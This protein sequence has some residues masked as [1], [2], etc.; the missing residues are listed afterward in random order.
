MYPVQAR[1]GRYRGCLLAL[2][3]VG[4][5]PTDRSRA[6][7]LSQAPDCPAAPAGLPDIVE[8]DE[9]CVYYDDTNLTEAQAEQAADDIQ[10]HWDR[11]TDDFGFRTP[12]YTDKLEVRLTNDAGCNGGTWVTW[13]Y[14]TTY[15]GCFSIPEQAE[16]VLGHE[17][18]H[19]VQYSYDGYE[20][21]WFKEGTARTM[22]DMT[23]EHLDHWEDAPDIGF[24]FNDDVD[25][26]LVNTNRD[27]TS[28]PMRYL[29]T[30]WWK[31]FS[32]QYGEE[33]TEPQ[34]GVDAFVDLWESAETRDDIAAVNWTLLTGEEPDAN[35]NAAFRQFT[36]VNWT[37]D[38]NNLPSPTNRY[39][40]LDEDEP[41]N[42]APYGPI[43]PTSG[44]TLNIDNSP[45]NFTNQ[46]ISR[47]GARYYQVQPGSN[48][49]LIS[50]SFS[51]LD[52]DPAFYHVVTQKGANFAAHVSG[53]GTNWTQS[54][55]NDGL[56]AVT[57]IV[58]SEENASDVDVSFLC[59]DPEIAI[60]MPNTGARSF[61]G[62]SAAPGKF[63]AQVLVTNSSIAN[64]PVV[65]GLSVSDF[66]ATVNGVNAF[67]TTGG[68]VQEQYW[69][70]IQAPAQ[71]SD[72]TYDLEITLEAPGTATPIA[73][74]TNATSVTYSPNNL[75]HVLVVDRSGSMGEDNKMEAAKRAA[76][77]YVDI[78]RNNDGLAVVPYNE[79]VNPSPFDMATVNATVRT[80]AHTFVDGLTAGGLTSIGDGLAEAV[81][82]Y[83]ASP[84]DNDNCS[85]VLLSDGM[86]NSDERWA[87]VQSDVVGTGC[88]VTTIAFGQATDE[89]LLQNIASTTGGLFFFNDVYISALA[90]SSTSSSDMAFNLQSTFELADAEVIG[91]ER[92]LTAKGTAP[93]ND[94]Q[95][96]SFLVDDT[97]SEILV[98]LSW[99]PAFGSTV[100]LTVYDP[101]GNPVTGDYV[102][103]DTASGYRGV[104]ID[105]PEPGAWEVGVEYQVPIIT[106][107]PAQVGS[108]PYQ[109]IV[110]GP[111]NLTVDLLLPDRLDQQYFTG[112]SVPIYAFLSSDSGPISGFVQAVVTAPDGTET[113]IPLFDDG[114]HGDGAADD[115]FYAGRYT[116]VNQAEAVSPGETQ[117]EDPPDE[118][119]YQVRV[120]VSRFDLNF[121]REAFGSFA[122][123]EGDDAN[124]NNIPDPFEEEHQL[125]GPGDPDLDL[126]PNEGEYDAGTD[127]NDSDSD[128]GG[129]NDGSEVE[130]GQDPLDP[131]DDQIEA[132]E[133]F[134]ADA[135]NVETYLFYDVKSEYTRIALYRTTDPDGVWN[136][137]GDEPSLT[138][139]HTDTNV[140]NGTT[141]YYRMFGVDED[142]HRSAVLSSEGVT[143][144]ED[145]TPPEGSVLINDDAE[146]TPTLNVS[147]SFVPGQEDARENFDDITE[148]RVSNE[149][150]AVDGA[151][152]QPFAPDIPWTL[153]PTTS[154]DW[155]RVYVQFRDDAGNESVV[156]TDRIIYDPSVAIPVQE[157]ML[158][159]PE[160]GM[161]GT[162]YA[163]TAT[164]SPTSATEPISYT[165]EAT[166]HPMSG[167]VLSDT[168]A[169]SWD[170]AGVKEVRVVAM[171]ATGTASA[172]HTIMI[173]TEQPGGVQEVMLAGPESGMVGTDYAFTA[174]VSPTSATEPISYTWEATDHP[175]SGAVLSDTIAF[176]WD[177]AG[178]KEV[179]V[180]A[181]NATGTASATHTI[182]IST[183][184]PGG[185][186]AVM[187]AGP[188]SGMVGT[189]YAF[190]ATVSPTSATEPISY[191]WEAT[192]QEPVTHDGTTTKDTMTFSWTT[193]GIKE[194]RVTAMN[195][196]GS[197]SASHNITI[198]VE[199]V[200]GALETVTISGTESGQP[201]VAYT[202]TA[203][204]EPSDASQP[205]SYTW[206]ATGQDQVTHTGG[207][208][209][210]TVSFMWTTEGTK[211][212]TVRAENAVNM[213]SD[214]F[215]IE[216]GSGTTGGEGTV[217]LP[218][219]LR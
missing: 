132:P 61:V 184:Q 202:F 74:D 15:S 109:V 158:A 211:E 42:P 4:L 58:G 86:E 164:V 66:K 94:E 78:T 22:Q 133:F 165:W 8:R 29:S 12:L 107:A 210:D 105:N 121:Q 117:G 212:L 146:R 115:G 162:D 174:T 137:L 24:S 217:Y 201:N 160:S 82:Q 138:G 185:V 134:D 88:P 207:G 21:K 71:V 156:D 13:N 26:Y 118:G 104:R 72:G 187:L 204:A 124:S 14:L 209:E 186:Q 122:V 84:T 83:E 135:G 63:L 76:N 17:L 69:L 178:M 195:A 91:R 213:V 106:A 32:E 206:E 51:N 40:Y 126:L 52:N 2:I 3:L 136:L 173:S 28:E 46:Q 6:A 65:A 81:D 123:Q 127:P 114:E 56:T 194:V 77:F 75:D 139:V 208:L 129:E 33:T 90:Q 196:D 87:D 176:L 163:F 182:M 191:T 167:A 170:T 38:L 166:D 155:A 175:M 96:H 36:L 119:S 130:Q 179:R 48:C 97:T 18:F 53:S 101:D 125:A 199:P 54:F 144:S 203:I 172:T 149:E 19:R 79:D 1:A 49:P 11:Y 103:A 89:T 142:N 73:A 140:T 116:L 43:V 5:V 98:A 55:L 20:S 110:S 80:N 85:F 181:M 180:V 93:Q 31:F 37:K 62:P 108:V 189:D 30:L 57:A 131:S 215:S 205:V 169:F 143:P 50:V 95:R 147:L 60:Q 68:F 34:R 183:E 177:T 154:G 64:A 67:I 171:N 218:L 120:S 100:F 59:A 44:G 216:V 219:I 153:A 188:E 192:D 41:G 157:V 9:F 159:G 200:E 10:A 145:P 113:T 102:F 111:S 193:E 70:V 152:W 16:M 45:A 161:V 198:Q 39:N 25:D 214:S 141:Y 150:E 35:F 197:A 23:F 99:D 112:N 7:P 27:L 148:V 92:L 168:M 128:G 151:A 190:T 47:Y